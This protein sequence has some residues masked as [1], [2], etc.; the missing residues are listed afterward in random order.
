M[1]TGRLSSPKFFADALLLRPSTQLEGLPVQAYTGRSHQRVHRGGKTRIAEFAVLAE[2]CRAELRDLAARVL[3]SSQDADDV[4]QEALLVA[5]V[6][7]SDVAAESQTAAWLCG[8]VLETA[9][10]A[11]R[12]RAEGT[13]MSTKAVSLDEKNKGSLTQIDARMNPE[14]HYEL[15]EMRNLASTVLEGMSEARRQVFRM[16]VLEELPRRQV[17]AL[18]DLTPSNVKALSFLTKRALRREV[19]KL[20]N[21]GRECA[22]AHAKSARSPCGPESSAPVHPCDHQKWSMGFVEDRLARGRRIQV[23]TLIN[24]DDREC[25]ALQAGTAL[26]GEK[27]AAVLDRIIAYRGAPKSIT[28]NGGTEFVS[29]DMHHWLYVNRIHSDIVRPG[30]PFDNGYIETFNR[31]LRDEC[32]S[33]DVFFSVAEVRRKLELWRLNYNHHLPHYLFSDRALAE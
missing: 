11:D 27:V 10:R 30:G 29:K 32:L 23:L 26:S 1:N 31:R 12:T 5:F 24:Q 25:L 7:L 22:I 20:S 14:R 33:V 15:Q 18:L 21:W 3:G 6:S 2:R 13:L 16:C 9:L 4:V 28:L 19:S 17:A 8:I